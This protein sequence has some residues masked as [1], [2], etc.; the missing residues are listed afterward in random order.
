[1]T[2]EMLYA[3]IPLPVV[4][5]RLDHQRPST[6]LNGYAKPSTAQMAKPR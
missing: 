3:G 1:M 6:T 4:A 2:T 5:S